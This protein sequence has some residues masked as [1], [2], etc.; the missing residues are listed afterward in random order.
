M[1]A[2]LDGFG[3]KSSH[4]VVTAHDGDEW[5]PGFAAASLYR[6]GV[7]TKMPPRLPR[8]DV[9]RPGGQRD[10]PAV[11]WRCGGATT[12][13]GALKDSTMSVRMA[14]VAGERRV[15]VAVVPSGRSQA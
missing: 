3:G 11:P 2:L 10:V 9:Q 6:P 14:P 7:G 5:L 12:L 15:R 1:R 8:G 4:V 13:A